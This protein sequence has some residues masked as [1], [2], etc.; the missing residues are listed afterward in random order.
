MR[1]AAARWCAVDDGI[2]GDAGIGSYHKKNPP[3]RPGGL[4]RKEKREI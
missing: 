2:L 1:G 3:G 4:E